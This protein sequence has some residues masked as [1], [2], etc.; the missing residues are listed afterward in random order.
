MAKKMTHS[1][2]RAEH[3]ASTHQVHWCASKPSLT[4]F[5]GGCFEAA[6]VAA[7]QARQIR[8]NRALPGDCKNLPS[9]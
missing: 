6:I 9:Q 1:P 5:L 7:Q 8:Q 4:G 3:Q 2:I